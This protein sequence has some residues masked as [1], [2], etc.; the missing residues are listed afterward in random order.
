MGEAVFTIDV[1]RDTRLK[2]VMDNPFEG[3]MAIDEKGIVFFVNAFFLEILNCSEQEVVGRQ[4]WDIV[5]NCRLYET[6]GQGYSI[7]GETLK[8]NAKEF[9]VARFPLKV[10]GQVVGAMVKT[11]FPDQTVAKE[12]VHKLVQPV[13]IGFHQTLCTCRDIIGETV[14]MLYVKKLARRASRTSSTLLITGESGTGK[15][16]VAQA[17]HTRS[18]RREAPFITVNCGAI[19]ENLL[20]S[21]LF[22]YV[23]GA[24]TGAKKGGKPGK[25]ELANGGTILL[26]EIGDMPLYMQVKLLRVLQEREVWRVGATSPTKLDVRVMASTNTDLKQ[27]AKDKKFREDLYYR[28]NV[29]EINLPPLRERIEDLPLLIE[30][31]ICRINSKIGADA[32]AITAASLDILQSYNWPGNVRELENLL[33]QAINWSEDAVI[34]VRKI[35]IKPWEL[36]QLKAPLQA[37]QPFRNVVE[38]TERDLIISALQ[39]TNGNK[40]MAARMLNIQRSVLYKKLERMNIAF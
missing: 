12:I 33:E 13:K 9:L 32:K 10:G 25:F 27:L 4:I 30:A 5:P 17:I 35:P 26:D 21:E 16:I 36:D 15:E 24:F 37:E 20:E 3:I 40:A 22:G 6:V 2:L 18:I 34:D 39:K 1:H 38:Q 28:L 7:W 8:I 11:I 14:P 31:L 29:L 23:D 19:P